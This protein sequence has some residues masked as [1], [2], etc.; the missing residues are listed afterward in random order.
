MVKFYRPIT[1]KLQR[2]VSER[3]ETGVTNDV[4]ITFW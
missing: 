2:S 1:Q 3:K 4:V